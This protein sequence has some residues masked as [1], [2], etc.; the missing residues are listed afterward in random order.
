MNELHECEKCISLEK[1]QLKERLYTYDEVIE[2]LEDFKNLK[3]P[4][5][6]KDIDYYEVEL[7]PGVVQFDWTKPA[8]KFKK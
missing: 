3:Y 7:Y 4:K 2:Y 1:E 8:P 5:K 6:L